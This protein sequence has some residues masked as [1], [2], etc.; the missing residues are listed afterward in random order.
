MGYVYVLYFDRPLHHAQR[1]LGATRNFDTRLKYHCKGKGSHITR[2]A[3]EQGIHLCIE[4]VLELP[5]YREALALERKLKRWKNNRKAAE[6]LNL[7]A[8]QAFNP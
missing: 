6:F 3:R 7:L 5:T 4:A 2:A 1:Y 8:V